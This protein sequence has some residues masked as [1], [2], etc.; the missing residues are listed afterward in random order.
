MGGK[1][2]QKYEEKELVLTKMRRSRARQRNLSD[3]RRRKTQIRSDQTRSNQRNTKSTNKDFEAYKPKPEFEKTE[4]RRKS[5]EELGDWNSTALMERKREE[6]RKGKAFMTGL[7]FVCF[8]RYVFVSLSLSL[9]PKAF[10]NLVSQRLVSFAS[11][12]FPFYLFLILKFCFFIIIRRFFF[13]LFSFGFSFMSFWT[14]S[15]V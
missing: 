1:K 8:V 7:C 10:L 6:R 11:P 15:W 5:E 13:F 3:F 2:K 9:S 12:F 14:F 4:E